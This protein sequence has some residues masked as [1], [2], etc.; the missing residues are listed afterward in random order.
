MSL[1]TT[2]TVVTLSFAHRAS[3]FLS[4]LVT[5]RLRL[6]IPYTLLATR[7]KARSQRTEG[8]TKSSQQSFVHICP[9][10]TPLTKSPGG[11]LRAAVWASFSPDDPQDSFAGQQTHPPA[12]VLPP[13]VQATFVVSFF[14]CRGLRRGHLARRLPI[15][16]AHQGFT[17]TETTHQLL[18]IVERLAN[19]RLCGRQLRLAPQKGDHCTTQQWTLNSHIQLQK[20]GEERLQ[21]SLP[22]Q[23]TTRTHANHGFQM[24]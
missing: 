16:C 10:L 11:C 6:L 12:Q 15:R 20:R 24:T 4:L 23:Q 14:G 1:Q 8:L 5:L 2:Q 22:K 21:H 18:R 3:I 17:N 7:R 9:R 19:Q 13:A